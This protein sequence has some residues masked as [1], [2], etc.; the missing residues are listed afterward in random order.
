[1]VPCSK[2]ATTTILHLMTGCAIR[3]GNQS[4]SCRKVRMSKT[5]TLE[6]LQLPVLEAGSTPLISISTSVIS[7][8]NGP[9][10]YLAFSEKVCGDSLNSLLPQLSYSRHC[11]W[12]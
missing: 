1:M 6:D 7:I 4:D 10:P 3:T 11:W 2:T 12:Y 9:I 5:A 8:C